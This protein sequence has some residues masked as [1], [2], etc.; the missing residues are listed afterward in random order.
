MIY[1]Y[2]IQ[3]IQILDSFKTSPLQ[4]YA[5]HYF[6]VSSAH[7]SDGPLLD[8]YCYYFYYSSAII[9]PLSVRMVELFIETHTFELQGRSESRLS[10]KWGI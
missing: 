5:F 10:Y 7:Y 2:F 1:M 8:S 9:M 4:E 3:I 6:V